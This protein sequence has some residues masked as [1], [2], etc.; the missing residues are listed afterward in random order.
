MACE[1]SDVIVIIPGIMGSTL[2]EPDGK[3]LWGVKPG[4]LLRSIRRLG[5]N[6]EKLRLP[7]RI[8]DSLASDGVVPGELIP[9]PHVVGKILG[10]DGY[11]HLIAWLEKTFAVR[12]PKAGSA[13]NLIPF[14]YDWRLSNRF[15]AKRVETELVPLLEQ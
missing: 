14:P 2:F 4:T 8:G 9:I 11:G 3:E 12:Q 10:S 15:T 13:G 1:M 5:S 6:F 7:P